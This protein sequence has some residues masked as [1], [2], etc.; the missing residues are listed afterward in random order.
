M[1]RS[2]SIQ[3]RLSRAL[4][5]F[6]VYHMQICLIIGFTVSD[7]RRYLWEAQRSRYFL[8]SLVSQ[9]VA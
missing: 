2:A 5:H 4:L 8:F 9:F 1:T 7:P 3:P 6:E